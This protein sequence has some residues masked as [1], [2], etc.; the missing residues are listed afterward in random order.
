MTLKTTFR[1]GL[2]LFLFLFIFSAQRAYACHG[3]AL[4]SPLVSAGPSS[5]TINASSDPASCGCGP[6]YLEVEL[7]TLP[8]GF[9][10]APPVYT[11]P[12]WG[13]APWYHSL[14]NVVGY[15]PP[16]WVDNCMMEPYTA[17]VIP[18]SSLCSGTTFYLKMRE[19]VV[20][21][22]SSGPWTAVSSFTTPGA[23]PTA[24]VTAT[25]SALTICS[26]DSVLLSA[27][28]TGCIGG[29]SYSWLPAASLTNPSSAITAATPTVTT[30]YTVTFTD[31]GLNQTATATVT[32][33]VNSN[34]TSSLNSMIESGCNASSGT[35]MVSTTG[36]SAPYAYNWIP[37]G[38]T[39]A[40]ATG[41]PSGT[42]TVMTTDA[43][44]CMQA[45]S[46]VVGDSCDFVWP[47]D[48]NDDAVADVIDILDIAIANGATGTTRPGA[49]LT[50]I[51][52]PSAN[53]G[54]T[55]LSGTDYKFV[56]CN[57]D[58]TIDL[59]DTNAVILNYGF[60]HNNRMGEFL[61]GSAPM[62]QVELATDS[63]QAGMPGVARILLGSQSQLA[64]NI[65]GI[66]FTLSFDPMQVDPMSMSLDLSSSWLGTTGVNLTGLRYTETGWGMVDVAI[67]RYDHIDNS[68]MGEIGQLHFMTTNTL[69]GTG[70]SQIVPLTISNVRLVN[71]TGVILPIS[72]IVNDTLTVFDMISG[73]S[74]PSQISTLSLTPNPGDGQFMLQF[75]VA[76]AGVYTTEV[77]NVLGEVVYSEQ[78]SVQQS[79]QRKAI[80]LSAIGSGVYLV[81]VSGNGS[82]VVERLIIK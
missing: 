52:Q 27:S 75:N 16:N 18:Y 69:T 20:G 15:G 64:Y 70:N 10:G 23:A 3:T 35:A 48:A 41:L 29:Y 4:M 1:T 65:Y 33:N 72:S 43:N 8:A 66:A 61:A 37:T 76:V 77:M 51:G 80:D 63:L 28:G 40:I 73:I 59:N 2:G 49:T 56:D 82:S 78:F 31:Y 7:S 74:T 6:Y 53:W 38:G 44:G 19:Y 60:T 26:G 62:M 68:G 5:V 13:A 71:P 58:G 36:G 55:L 47:G 11:S 54:T 57:G 45:L 21:S 14:L 9:T 12:S 39:S 81:R 67:T 17:I 50:W 32:I 30:T 24:S 46:I 22:S 79:E 42:Y 34:P 25:A